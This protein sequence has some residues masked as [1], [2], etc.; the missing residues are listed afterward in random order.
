MYIPLRRNLISKTFKSLSAFYFFYF[1]SVG[2][3]IIFLPEILKG[4]GYTPQQIGIIFS[5]APIMRFLTPFIFLKFIKLTKRVFIISLVGSITFGTIA[6]MSVH[7]FIML[8]ISYALLGAFWSTLL[9]FA[10]N[11]ALRTIKEKYGKSRLFGS[12]GFI[13]IGLILGHLT[14]QYELA[15][16]AYVGTIALTV[17]FGYLLSSEISE[18]KIQ[19]KTKEED[20]EKFSFLKVWQFWVMGL[21]MQISFGGMYNFFTIYELENGISLSMISWLWT[22]GVTAEIFMFI[23]QTNLLK[24]DL[25]TLIKIS[26]FLT[27][28][29]WF[30]LYLYP[31]ELYVVFLTQGIHAFSL[32]LFHTASITYIL[33]VYSSNKEL[34]QQFYLGIC[35]GLGGFLGSLIAGI[36]YGEFLFLW[37]SLF[38]F[39]GFIFLFLKPSFLVQNRS[40]I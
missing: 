18:N 11:I 19:Q 23:Y 14:L 2:V 17:F 3:Y 31:Q 21:L 9:P 8:I 20:I 39:I 1:A 35:Y 25:I 26:V 38:A 5:V 15:A 10:E 13:L 27:S 40:Q 30:L 28:I 32:A 33:K 37:M 6:I 29:R 22:F 7:S 24:K 12:I 16:I 34:G 36:V 4:F